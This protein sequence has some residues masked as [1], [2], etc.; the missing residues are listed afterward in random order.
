MSSRSRFL[1]AAL[2]T[3]GSAAAVC[4]APQYGLERQAFDVAVN[5]GVPPSIFV[6]MIG[7]ESHFCPATVSPKGAVGLGQLMPDTAR[8][9]RVTNPLNI[10]QNLNASA[11]Y[12]RAQFKT[13]G[14][15]DLAL[16]AYNA[17]AGNVRKYGG[18]PP[19]AETVA[20]VDKVLTRAS[21]LE[22]GI[23]L[24]TA[25]NTPIAQLRTLPSPARPQVALL[26]AS[27]AASPR[28]VSGVQAPV[29]LVS[30]PAA[31]H[32]AGGAGTASRGT[33]QPVPAGVKPTPATATSQP[34]PAPAAA[35]IVTT[36]LPQAAPA[37]AARST[38][39]G[40]PVT[41]ST[42]TDQRILVVIRRGTAPQA[43]P[44]AAPAVPGPAGA[45][46]AA[47]AQAAPSSASTGL[48]VIRV[49]K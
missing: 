44:G 17:G 4:P 35:R 7:T 5:Q 22:R 24:I 25:L 45:P 15:W 41:A 8:D 31:Q 49:R 1:T 6:A 48:V 36:T 23:P 12:L 16:A 32:I 34:T 10:A 27:Q 11:T 46:Q 40:G 13:F 9:L 29:T 47:P 20:H 28:N 3:S 42:V 39:P 19:F 43:A 26:A 38:T 21:A 33:I 37:T 18:I 14:R 2:L 30:S